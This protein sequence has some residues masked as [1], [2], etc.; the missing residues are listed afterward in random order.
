MNVFEIMM[1]FMNRKTALNFNDLSRIFWILAL[2]L[3]AIPA[4]DKKPSQVTTQVTNQVT[5]KTTTKTETAIVAGGCFWGMEEILRQVPGILETTV[6]YSG[7]TL[8]HPTYEKVKKGDT[9]HAEAVRIVF[10]PAQLSYAE[11]LEKWFFKMHDPTTRNRQGNDIGSQYRS[12][13]FYLSEEQRKT[14]EQVKAKIDASGKWKSPIVTEITRASEF[15]P[16]E[17][18]HQK[19]LIKNPGGYTC[20][21]IRD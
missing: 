5:T 15:T 9:G 11:I 6:G 12:A 2:S 1:R 13:I 3:A 4:C 21:W 10:D 20:H 8:A 17:D 7:G 16:A 14:A 19:Y 18:Y